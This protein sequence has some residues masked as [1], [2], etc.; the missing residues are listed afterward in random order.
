[1][2]RLHYVLEGDGPTIVLSHALGSDLGM[3]DEVAAELKPGFTVLRYDHRG[4]GRSE[5]VPGRC[6]LEDLADDASELIAQT[7]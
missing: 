5:P 1:M 3:W 4:H 7:V 2:P 6:T